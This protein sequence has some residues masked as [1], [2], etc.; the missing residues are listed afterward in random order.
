MA[1]LQL[2]GKTIEDGIKD[3]MSGDTADAYMAVGTW[4]LNYHSDFNPA[5]QS[6]VYALIYHVLS[7]FTTKS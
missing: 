5:H 1:V 4:T 3:G 6:C 7:F 2:S